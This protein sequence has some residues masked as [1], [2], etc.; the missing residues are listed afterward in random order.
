MKLF[1]IFVTGIIVTLISG[2]AS[3]EVLGKEGK[4]T[5]INSDYSEENQF[6][7][8]KEACLGKSNTVSVPAYTPTYVPS[9]TP[10]YTSGTINTYNQSTNS[11][12]TST[13]SGYSSPSGGFAGGFANGV[14]MAANSARNDA[15]E[16]Q[17][18]IFN[19]CMKNLGWEKY[20]RETA[21][22]SV[23]FSKDRAYFSTADTKYTL[24]NNYRSL[25][26]GFNREKARND[27]KSNIEQEKI[28]S[29]KIKYIEEYALK[30]IDKTTTSEAYKFLGDIYSAGI[31]I[32][33]NLEKAESYYKRA[34][35]F[36][37]ISSIEILAKFYRTGRF[38]FSEK[39]NLNKINPSES[40][41]WYKKLSGF[42][43]PK[44]QE[45]KM[46]AGIIHYLNPDNVA[47]ARYYVGVE[48]IKGTNIEPNVQLGLNYIRDAAERSNKL[49]QMELAIY[50]YEIG[51]K[52][53]FKYWFD[54]ALF[55]QYMT[56]FMYT[57]VSELAVFSKKEYIRTLLKIKYDIDPN[58]NTKYTDF[59]KGITSISSGY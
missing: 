34:G 54:K 25:L 20:S 7:L 17:S 57:D 37:E 41:F 15:I 58:S 42:Y 59:F 6:D 16:A 8:D 43:I 22:F 33:Q 13:Y 24:N 5:K 28:N 55:Q 11:F 1:S 51:D 35:E 46:L 3:K 18:I 53:K 39:T 30:E 26:Y 4:W 49:A 47:E 9:S 44:I 21:T 50:Y 52:Q 10:S 23:S 19:N 48:Y 56:I 14:A 32:D 12:S 38:R 40:L 2:C 31:F 27:V 29:E 36:N 45:E